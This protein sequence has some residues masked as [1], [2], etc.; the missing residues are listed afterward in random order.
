VIFGAAGKAGRLITAEAARRGHRVTAVVRNVSK[1]I[2]LP[3]GVTGAMG[4]ATSTASIKKFAPNADVFILTIGGSDNTVWKRA[5]QT[6]LETLGS[7][8]GNVP[9][10]L[11]MG[12]GASL[13]TSDGTRFLDL[14]GFPELFRGPAS[15]QAEALDIYRK[16][17][18]PNVTW[19][20]I[21]PPPVNF[22]LG[23]RTGKYRTGRDNPV[24]DKNGQAAISYE[25]FA[26]ALI[27]EVEQPRFV[28]M[29]FTVGY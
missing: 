22:T 16:S 26:V 14:P 23:L 2:D 5:A 12:G 11:H 1:L 15:G 3:P 24:S 21:S 17:S 7:I 27:D 8:S 6:L 4:D 28:N 13:L 10:I 9:R 20:Y 19:T 25:D 29:R 18:N